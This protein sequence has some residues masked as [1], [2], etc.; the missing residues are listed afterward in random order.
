MQATASGNKIQQLLVGKAVGK[1]LDQAR[2]GGSA[3]HKG[4]NP[5]AHQ[6]GYQL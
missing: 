1:S 5:I 2:A 4:G 3:D 6:W